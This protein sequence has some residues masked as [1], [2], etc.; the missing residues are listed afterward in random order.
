L[1]CQ[2]WPEK[3]FPLQRV[4]TLKLTA[5]TANFFND[6]EQLAFSPAHVVPGAAP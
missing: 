3:Q 2:I 1:Y 6:N 5:N 4:G